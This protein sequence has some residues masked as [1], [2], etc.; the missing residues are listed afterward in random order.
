M[1]SSISMSIGSIFAGYKIRSDWRSLP[2]HLHVCRWSMHA[3]GK[4]KFI[5]LTFGILPFFA[6]ILLATMNENSSPARLWFS[7][8][9]EKTLESLHKDP[10]I[11]L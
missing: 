9:S 1:P 4:Y 11:V 2:A 3:M 5:N 8:V 6:T 10:D 7:I